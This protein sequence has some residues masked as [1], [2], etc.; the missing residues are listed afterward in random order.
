MSDR[1][2]H[3]P[4]FRAA[5]T[6][7]LA[8]IFSPAL[9]FASVEGFENVWD[10]WFE[11]SRVLNF[12]NIPVPNDLELRAPRLQKQ[13]DDLSEE[14]VERYRDLKQSGF[15]EIQWEYVS[16]KGVVR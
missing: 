15:K 1:P 5:L 11:F 4:V 7:A 6:A 2:S 14:W 9:G 8:L 3:R 12:L 13:S 10:S 16:G